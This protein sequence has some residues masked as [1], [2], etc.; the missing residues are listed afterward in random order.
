MIKLLESSLAEVTRYLETGY[1]KGA[2]HAAA[3]YREVF[4]HGNPH[5]LNS[6]EFLNS[7]RLARDLEPV[8]SVNPGTIT[9]TIT[10]GRLLKFI[11]RLADGLEIESVVI[12]M[13][14]YSTLCISSQIGCRMGCV[15]CQTGRLGLRRSLTVEEITG[16]VYNARHGLKKPIKNVVFMGM[17]EPLDNL[18]AVVRSIRI[19][20]EQ[21]GFNI[22]LPHITVSTAGYVPGIRRLAEL[23]WPQVRLAVSVNAPDDATRSRLMPINRKYGLAELKQALTEYPLTQRGLFL[24]EYILI[25]GV[26]DSPD[27]ALA[28]AG[29]LKPLPVRLNL[30]AYNPVGNS[31]F[32]SPSDDDLHRFKTILTEQGIFVINRWSKGR[33]VTAGCGQLGRGAA[34]PISEYREQPGKQESDLKVVPPQKC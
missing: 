8:I 4:Q 20:N 11:T 34:P 25:R 10:E 24:M 27:H 12:P 9:E 17:G 21:K 23:N 30:I 32:Q 14:R 2:F 13:T 33:S 15:F 16:Q 3:L 7:P 31:D 5:P 18:D 6:P 29:Y 28:L 1:G 19:L 26:N 22:A